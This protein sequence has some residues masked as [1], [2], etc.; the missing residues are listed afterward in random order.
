[1]NMHVGFILTKSPSEEGFATFFKFACLYLFKNQISIYLV[2]NGVYCARKNHVASDKLKKLLQGSKI[3][4]KNNDLEARG[5]KEENLIEGIIPFCQYDQMVV[6]V[7][8]NFD[9]I[10]S[11]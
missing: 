7:M 1:M 4:A 5:I 3:Y 6:D 10:L 11:F 2:G 9:Q 8:E